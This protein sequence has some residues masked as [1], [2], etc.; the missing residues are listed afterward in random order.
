VSRLHTVVANLRGDH[1]WIPGADFIANPGLAEKLADF[2]EG[3]DA[4]LAG[5]TE[6]SE[7]AAR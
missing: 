5:E 6:N 2:I 3:L 4:E 7:P 1:P